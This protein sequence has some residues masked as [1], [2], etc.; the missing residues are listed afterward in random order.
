MAPS[1]RPCPPTAQ[2]NATDS[3]PPPLMAGRIVLLT[4]ERYSHKWT[5][6]DSLVAYSRQRGHECTPL[7]RRKRFI[8]RHETDDR[9]HAD[10][11][12]Y[13]ASPAEVAQDL[14]CRRVPV[15]VWRIDRRTGSA[16]VKLSHSL[17]TTPSPWDESCHAGTTR[18]G[19]VCEAAAPGT[20]LMFQDS[21]CSV[22]VG[23]SLSVLVRPLRA[24]QA[25]RLRTT[26]RVRRGHA[27]SSR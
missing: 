25:P 12:Y 20:M 21:A 26:S 2:R 1:P 11:G 3:L 27:P 9:D 6:T 24:L 8:T 10:S 13:Q 4:Q 5:H 17:G 7:L 19:V 23:I 15:A 22:S 18:A 14:Y 16:P